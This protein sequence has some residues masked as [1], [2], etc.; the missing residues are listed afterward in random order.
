MPLN[1]TP[2]KEE[3]IWDRLLLEDGIYK[4]KI[5]NAIEKKNKN[6][7]DMLEIHL[8]IFRENGTYKSQR[9]WI[10]GNDDWAW[11][12]RHLSNSC[13]LIDIYEEG[14]LEASD[15][16][17]KIAYAKIGRRKRV[18]DDGSIRNENFIKDYVVPEKSSE[19]VKSQD[20][21]IDNLPDDNNF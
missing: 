6:N 14:K 19:E 12:L 3:E 21:L 17:N 18:L 16:Y 4:I 1:Y 15:L 20:T 8:D 7:E 5:K 11:K 13:G 10:V 9:D 2:R